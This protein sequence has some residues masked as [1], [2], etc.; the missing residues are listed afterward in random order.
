MNNLQYQSRRLGR[1]ICYDRQGRNFIPAA[2]RGPAPGVFY[3][4]DLGDQTG[5]G[6][7]FRLPTFGYKVSEKL[8]RLRYSVSLFSRVEQALACS[9][10]GRDLP[11]DTG[12]D[13]YTRG[14]PT[15]ARLFN[16]PFRGPLYKHPTIVIFPWAPLPGD[17]ET[18]RQNGAS[19][20]SAQLAWRQLVPWATGRQE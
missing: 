14:S 7:R 13:I 15:C 17:P 20:L 12:S 18:N 1:S 10:A 11:H 6:R 8:C 2:T 4:S 16:E 9:R 19:P 3:I 5:W